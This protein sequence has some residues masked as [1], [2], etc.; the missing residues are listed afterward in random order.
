MSASRI[1]TPCRSEGEW[2]LDAD[3]NAVCL[4][5]YQGSIFDDPEQT[6]KDLAATIN[7]YDGDKK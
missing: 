1:K 3:G 6:A 5:T 7:F 2:V 4:A